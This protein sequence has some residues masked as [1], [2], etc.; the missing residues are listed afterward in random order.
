[1]NKRIYWKIVAV[2][3]IILV[4]D[5]VL[6]VKRQS[7]ILLIPTI[8]D[9]LLDFILVE[10]LLILGI[11]TKSIGIKCIF[12]TKFIYKI[13]N[14][15]VKIYIV[16]YY[17]SQIGTFTQTLDIIRHIQGIFSNVGYVVGSYIVYREWKANKFS[18]TTSEK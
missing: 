9:R 17:T 14:T 13:I 2:A 8:V 10:I 1:M 15:S 6:F 12:I 7:D 11:Q 3:V 18:T 4:G 16:Y 5:I